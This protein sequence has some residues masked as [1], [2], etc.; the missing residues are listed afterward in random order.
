[1]AWV[2]QTAA[3]ER[4]VIRYGPVSV[5]HGDRG[6]TTECNRMPDGQLPILGRTTMMAM[7]LR[8]DAVNGELVLIP[9][10]YLRI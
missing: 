6:T 8:V 3:G 9:P 5:A 10:P 2:E 7:G 4:E 1:M